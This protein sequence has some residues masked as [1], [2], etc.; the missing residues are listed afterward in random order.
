MRGVDELGGRHAGPPSASS[1]SAHVS[2]ASNS[3]SL[4][5]CRSRLYA[6]GRPLS[7]AR[8]PVRSPI[9]RPA[10]PRASSA[11]SGFFFCGSIDEPV[12]YASA[13]RRKPNSSVDHSTIS[14]PR[15]ERCTCVSVGDEQRLGDEVAV[16]H[17]VERVL[18]RGAR[19]R[20]RW[21][22]AAGSSG[23]LEPASAPAPSGDTSA[24][25]E[26]VAPAVDV[27]AERP[28]VREQVV[29]EQHRLRAL[30]VRVAGEVRRRSASSAR[31]SSTACSSW[32]RARPARA[33]APEEQPQVERDLVVAAAAGVQLGA[34]RARDL[35]DP[36]LDRGVDV[37]VGRR[38]RE[39]R[40]RRAPLRRGRARRR[41]P[42]RSS[43]GRAGRRASSMCDVRA[44]PGEVVGRE[45]A[46]ERQADGEREQLVGRALAEAAVPQR[47]RRV[48]VASLVG[49]SLT[50][51]PGPWRR[52]HV[53]ADRPH[54]RTK[55]SE[56]SWRNASSAS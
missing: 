48:A 30:Q 45:P 49:C 11:M 21:R 39:R 17:R 35:G 12:E 2:S 7:V 40:R 52:D 31:R 56:S 19:S 55:P 10:L 20:A 22:R 24:R 16:G 6:S 1:D 37:F 25:V 54:S 36:P 38:E 29:R 26:A 33:L 41:S 15:R 53:S 18:E 46:V 32:M 27:A 23:R 14:S 44:R 3:G 43:L 50:W 8:K 47:L 4:S 42:A 5:S 28:E 34:G 51:T 13:R 9:S